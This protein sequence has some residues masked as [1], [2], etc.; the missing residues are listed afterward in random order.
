MVHGI[1]CRGCDGQEPH[2]D[3]EVPGESTALFGRMG[4]STVLEQ[5]DVPSS[6]MGT[7]HMQE[8]LLR[9]LDLVLGDQ[10]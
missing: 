4:S 9:F 1:E 5:A 7:E 6:P 10:Q 3:P 2:L 8:P